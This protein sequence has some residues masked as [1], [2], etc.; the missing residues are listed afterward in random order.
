MFPHEPER[1]VYNNAVV[2]RGLGRTA[3]ADALARTGCVCRRGRRS[4]CGVGPRSGPCSTMRP[5]PARV[6]AGYD[7]PRAG[8]VAQDIRLPQPELAVKPLDWSD[9]V[10][11]FESPPG[12]LTEGDHATLQLTVAWLDGE[13]ASSALTHDHAGDCGVYNVGT[14]P[15]VCLDADSPPR[16]PLTFCTPPAHAAAS[17]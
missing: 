17:W 10:R 8:A 1:G 9:Y 4:L 2:R 12:L 13:P 11:V 5:G 6:Y 3:R 16:S 15:R 7:N 14:L